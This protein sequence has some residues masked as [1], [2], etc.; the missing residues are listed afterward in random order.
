VSPAALQRARLQGLGAQ[1]AAHLR[2][3]L[4][5]LRGALV[6]GGRFERCLRFVRQPNVEGGIADDKADHGGRTN[7][8]ISTPIFLEAKR[9][10]MTKAARVDDLTDQ[11]IESIYW[12]LFWIEP[13]AY[14]FPAPLDLLAF[15]AFVQHR[16]RPAAELMQTAVGAVP[17]GIIGP[18]TID[19]AHKVEPVAAI[20]RYAYARERLY[21]EIA[22]ADPTQVKFLRGWLNR[23]AQVRAA[24]LAEVA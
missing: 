15:D 5:D 17:D 21:R 4:R 24:A 6:S 3:D 18:K 2:E 12:A 1:A 20:E 8:G 9:R 7:A 16:P 10:G 19:A 22:K 14:L 11:E 23:A 13:K